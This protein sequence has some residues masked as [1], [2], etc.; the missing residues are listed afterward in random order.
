MVWIDM[1][2]LACGSDNQEDSRFCRRCGVPL[3]VSVTQ[4]TSSTSHEMDANGQEETNQVPIPEDAIVTR[5]SHWAYILYAIPLLVL[6]GV[7]LAVDFFTFGVLPMMVTFYIVWSRYQS[8]HKTAYILTEKHLIIFQGSLF[9]QKRIDLPF[10]NL[11][12]ILVRPGMFGKSL[13]YT[14]V[15]LQPVDQRMIVLQ[16][17]PLSSPLLE[18]LRVRM[19]SDS[20]R[21]EEPDE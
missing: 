21:Q 11:H 2:C 14:D 9:G 4:V 18:H 5:Q 19:N 12:N 15:R 13:G 6:F 16:Y 3:S 20:L 17:V 8:F 7:S 1:E 10:S